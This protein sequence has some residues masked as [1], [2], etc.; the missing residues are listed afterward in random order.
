MKH[1]VIELVVKMLEDYYTE[2]CSG[3]SMEYTFGFMDALAAVR[4]MSEDALAPV[5][6]IG[7]DIR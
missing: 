6:F 2:N 5:R 7:P 3:E 1:N 4:G